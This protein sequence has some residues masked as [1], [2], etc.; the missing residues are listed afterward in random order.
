MTFGVLLVGS[1]FIH[2][3]CAT[4]SATLEQS[5]VPINLDLQPSRVWDQR[6]PQFLCRSV[7][8]DHLMPQEIEVSPSGLAVLHPVGE[9]GTAPVPMTIRLTGGSRFDRKAET[10]AGVTLAPDH[11][12]DVTRGR[13][14]WL[15]LPQPIVFQEPTGSGRYRSPRAPVTN[16]RQSGGLSSCR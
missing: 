4:N 15:S 16:P 2:Y 12:E 7:L 5:A 9:N 11:G 13:D 10:M 6:D 3:Q 1:T 8:S 14:P